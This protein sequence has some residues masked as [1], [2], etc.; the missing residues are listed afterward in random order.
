ML[1]LRS[2]GLDGRS[3]R[4]AV[5]SEREALALAQHWRDLGGDYWRDISPSRDRRA[6]EP[7]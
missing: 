4:Q 7:G 2:G 5:H 6:A 1:R 3:R